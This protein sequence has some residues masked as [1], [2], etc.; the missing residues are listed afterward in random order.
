MRFESPTGES[1]VARPR[2]QRVF[3]SLDDE[4]FLLISSVIFAKNNRHRRVSEFAG[5]GKLARRMSGELL[6]DMSD[7]E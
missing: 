7:A 3:G 5:F 4:N 1:Q 6:A 2:V